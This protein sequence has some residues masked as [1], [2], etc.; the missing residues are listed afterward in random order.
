MGSLVTSFGV[1][2][3]IMGA[4]AATGEAAGD[5]ISWPVVIVGL[6]VITGAMD[7]IQRFVRKYHQ[8]FDVVMAV[9]NKARHTGDV[10]KRS[11]AEQLVNETVT[12]LA[13]KSKQARETGVKSLAKAEKSQ[14]TGGPELEEVKRQPRGRRFVR[15]LLRALPLAGRL[16]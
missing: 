1:A 15:G 8:A 6:L 5:E 14:G 9:L 12:Q 2:A 11:L 13:V 3:A 10:Q 16:M 7:H 4:V